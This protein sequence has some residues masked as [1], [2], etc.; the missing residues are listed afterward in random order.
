MHMCVVTV[1]ENRIV[2]NLVE[3]GVTWGAG[4]GGDNWGC[5]ESG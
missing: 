1:K 3:V 5:H 4:G 2:K